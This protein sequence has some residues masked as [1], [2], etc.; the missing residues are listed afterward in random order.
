MGERGIPSDAPSSS[1]ATDR[2]VDEWLAL[3]DAADQGG[4]F[5]KS[6]DITTQ[7][8]SLHPDERWLQHRAVLALARSGATERA[9]TLFRS[10]R[11][12]QRDEEDIA[13]L[14]AR[15]AK[16]YAVA[17]TGSERAIRAAV[18]AELYDEAF[19]RTG[20]FYSG[21][22]AATMWLL[23]G[24]AERATDLAR[25]VR[26]ACVSGEAAGLRDSYYVRATEAESSLILGDV[27]AARSALEQATALAGTDYAALAATRR[28][29]R[30][31]CECADLPLEILDALAVPTVIHYTGHMIGPLIP[32]YEDLVT[33][34][35]REL[36]ARRRVG[37]GYG[38]LAS[39]AD[40][41]FAEA[42][43]DKGAEV[44]VVLPCDDDRF[45]QMSVAGAGREWVARFR[46]CR[47]AIR[48]VTYA[49]TE[50]E[51]TDEAALDYASAIATG[52]AL[53]RARHLDAL[54][55]QMAVWDEQAVGEAKGG[56]E[57]GI[58]RWHRTGLTSHVI[59]CPPAGVRSR[60]VARLETGLPTRSVRA[61]LFGDVKGFSRLHESQIPRFIEGVMA[62]VGR[63]LDDHTDEILGQNTWG[64]G[65]FVV[66]RAVAA[67]AQCALDLQNAINAIRYSALGLPNDLTLRVAVHAG[68]VFEIADP[69]LKRPGF[70]GVHVTKAGRI[71]PVT[72]EGEVYVTEPFAALLALERP[73]NLHC[74]Y[75]G[76]M[77]TAKG[78]GSMRM[79]VLKRN[80]PDRRS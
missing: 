20:G 18:A 26:S 78:Y 62:V 33:R 23:A 42:L 57:A 38:S 67:A 56:T 31:I 4:E 80:Q 65:L 61:F 54:V 27:A 34:R 32:E 46:R 28:Q 51:L 9:R 43:I 39:G 63:V 48:S 73:Q 59:P 6:Y 16:D 77:P 76:H 69:V 30:L 21:V 74:E 64:D 29:L 79:Y 7:A 37:F 47:E 24:R 53:T 68:P 66:F 60:S 8:L 1:D 55:E 11:L 41:L 19:R 58:A 52:L 5:L 14:G 10:Y 71:E 3:I 40:I 72:P 13:A 49:S 75:V 12:T 35:I 45:V 44:H 22:N 15:L 36:V 17:A 2:P 70:F 50:L 25:A